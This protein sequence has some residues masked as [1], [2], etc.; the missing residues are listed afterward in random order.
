MEAILEVDSVLKS[1]GERR[2]LTDI[3]LSCRTGEIIGLMGRNGSGK[4]TLLRIL[5]GTLRSDNHFIRINSVFCPKPYL[6]KGL[7]NYLPQDAFLPRNLT[8]RKATEL[9]LP[10][11]AGSLLADSLIN[12]VSDCK[13]GV[14]SGGEGRYLEIRLILESGAQFILLDEP[15][16]GLSPLMIERV[17][18]LIVARSADAGI[19]LTD[20]DYRNVLDVA[21]RNYILY[22]GGIRPVRGREEL[23]G[24]GYLPG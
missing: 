6:A 13:I 15:Y 20:H 18:E 23:V 12:K 24:W 8:V 21:S 7:M 5:F 14:L 22:D 11:R 3:S 10:E 9:F 1:Y 19:I 4:S 17:K 2:V 16:N